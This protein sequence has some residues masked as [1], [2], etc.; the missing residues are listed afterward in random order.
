MKEEK[1]REIRV[2]IDLENLD[3]IEKLSKKYGGVGNFSL[4]CHWDTA[5]KEIWYELTQGPCILAKYISKEDRE[6]I[7]KILYKRVEQ[8]LDDLEE[9]AFHDGGW[10]IQVKK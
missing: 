7:L 10:E 8:I 3:R 1:I 6:A 2:E 5:S 4:I 9:I